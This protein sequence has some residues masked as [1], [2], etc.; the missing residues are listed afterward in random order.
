MKTL[1]ENSDN[2]S[3]YAMRMNAM[4]NSRCCAY[5]KSQA[6]HLYEEHRKS[7]VARINIKEIQQRVIGK[8]T[9]KNDVADVM[10]SSIRHM[11]NYDGILNICDDNMLNDSGNDIL[12]TVSSLC[13]DEQGLSYHDDA[14]EDECMLD[15]MNENEECNDVQRK[16]R[17]KKRFVDDEAD[18]SGENSGTDEECESSR[19][20]ISGL[21]VS[22]D[23]ECSESHGNIYN[24]DALRMDESILKGLYNRFFKNTTDRMK[25]VSHDV[26]N[27]L[28]TCISKVEDLNVDESGECEYNRESGD[29]YNYFEELN[30]VDDILVFPNEHVE[31]SED[32]CRKQTHHEY[33]EIEFTGNA[34]MIEKKLGNRKDVWEFSEKHE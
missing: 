27:E 24:E 16:K 10:L 19:D 4:G 20:E 23:E 3:A 34:D 30:D 21:I 11:R 13:N 2:L 31:Y 17:G 15:G 9:G 33:T 22:D 26:Q 1:G 8:I 18:V 14:I 12:S 6:R 7:V 32:A 5:T 28:E 29:E 25:I